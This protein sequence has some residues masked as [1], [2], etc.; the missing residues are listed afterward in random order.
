MLAKVETSKL[1]F[2]NLVLNPLIRAFDR[3]G[4]SHVSG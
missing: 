3:G 2:P 4:G 1:S